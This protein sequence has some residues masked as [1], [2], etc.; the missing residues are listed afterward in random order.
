[1]RKAKGFLNDLGYPFERHETITEDGYILGIHRI[2]HGKNEAINTTESKQK[3]A[4]LLMHGLFCSSVDYFIFG[5]ER[6][7]ALMLAD[8]GYDVWL[9]N[10]RGNTWSRNHTSLDPNVDKEFWDYR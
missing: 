6:S 3:P 8:E 7:I 10:N 2:P 5:P 1:M 4:V 9:G